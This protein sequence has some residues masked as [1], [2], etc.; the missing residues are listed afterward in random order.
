MYVW[1][2]V[3]VSMVTVWANVGVRLNY[4]YGKTLVPFNR[5][6]EL[7][8]APPTPKC[9]SVLGFARADQV[10]ACPRHRACARAPQTERERERE[11]E[12]RVLHACTDT[13]ASACAYLLCCTDV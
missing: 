11:R 8:L 1:P 9:L 5:V 3:C 4:R 12:R 6:D 2:S 7:Q 10:H 13:Y